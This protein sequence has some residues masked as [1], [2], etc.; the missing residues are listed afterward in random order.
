MSVNNLELKRYLDGTL[1]AHEISDYCP[2][3]LQVEGKAEIQRVVTGVTASQALID[4]AIAE[5]ADAI[6]VHHGYFWKGESQA[7]SGMKK[8]R[9]KALLEHDINLFAYHLPLDVHPEFGNNRQLAALLEIDNVQALSGVK[10]TGVV[11][12]GEF[13]K[14]MSQN[15]LQQRLA[16]MLGR[17][18]LA[19]GD[20]TKTIKTLAWCTG[21]GQGF[22]E[23]AVAAGVDAFITGEVSEQT[24]HT[25]REMGISFFAAGH[26]ATERY[27]VK[28]LGEHIQS[29]FNLDVTFIDIRNPA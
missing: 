13:E 10:P 27:G 1:R 16:D 8:K 9:I 24:I 7:I 29:E 20:E 4:A 17:T 3:G 14:P 26:H 19:E 21:G 23:Q 2:N 18:V 25:A 11:M 28:A 5:N 6:V 12:Q 15:E 22:I